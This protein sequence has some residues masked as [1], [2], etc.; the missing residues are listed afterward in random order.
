MKIDCTE[1]RMYQS[2]HCSDCLVTVLLHPEDAP[3]EIE[4]ELDRS[5]QAL[6]GAGLIPVLRFRPRSA[7]P[8]PDVVARDTA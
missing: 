1:C 4:P 6:S 8:P 7:A 5:L 2:E 3:V